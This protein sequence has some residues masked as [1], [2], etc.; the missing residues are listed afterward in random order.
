[1]ILIK[2]RLIFGIIRGAIVTVFKLVYSVIKLLRLQEVLLLLMVGLVLFLTG[3]FSN[4]TL[5]TLY[6]ITVAGSVVLTILYSIRKIFKNN[7]K[8]K[9][10]RGVAIMPNE[11]V[12]QPPVQS[13]MERYYEQRHEDYAKQE[14]QKAPSVEYVT[15]RYEAKIEE[16]V[17]PRYFAVKGHPGYYMAEYSD[18][19]ELYKNTETGLKKIRTDYKN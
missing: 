8:P 10:S 15:P 19:V 11:Y 1:M 9:K 6:V 3:A 12:E 4:S 7:K 13:D 2:N 18:R 16:R 5:L 14:L 17:T